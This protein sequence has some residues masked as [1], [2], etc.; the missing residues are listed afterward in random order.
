MSGVCLESGK[1]SAALQ[2]YEKALR[3]PPVAPELANNMAW[4]LLTAKDSS[5]R[6]PVRALDLARSAARSEQGY[7]LDTLATALW[8]N[9]RV[10][11]AVAV[12][13]KAVALDRENRSYYQERID[14]FQ[15]E[16]WGQE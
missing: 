9:G 13:K 10:E 11:E 4:L 7:I 1:E 6:N 3:F 8:A 14:T 12:E 15:Q 2:A 16:S 5:L